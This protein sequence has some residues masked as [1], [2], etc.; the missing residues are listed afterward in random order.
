MDHCRDV[1]PLDD[2]FFKTT[3]DLLVE[4]DFDS[5]RLSLIF[6]AVATVAWD[7]CVT[8]GSTIN[9]GVEASGVEADGLDVAGNVSEPG[10]GVEVPESELVT[11]TPL[12]VGSVDMRY[13]PVTSLAISCINA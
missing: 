4:C 1:L 13:Q 5:V 12:I 8:P 6:V 7:A 3:A 10:D 11:T 9:V 2:L